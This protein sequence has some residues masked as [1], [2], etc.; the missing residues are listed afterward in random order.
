MSTAVIRL[1]KS[2]IDLATAQGKAEFRKPAQQIQYWVKIARCVIDNPDLSFNEVK[3]IL[4]GLAE[5]EAGL[6]EEYEFS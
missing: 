3:G 1:E 6:V 5:A 2:V 4:E